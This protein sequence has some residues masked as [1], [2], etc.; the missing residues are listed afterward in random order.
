MRLLKL[1]EG[2]VRPLTPFTFQRLCQPQS[3]KQQAGPR[4]PRQLLS[5]THFLLPPQTPNASSFCL[6]GKLT[7]SAR[8]LGKPV[9][10]GPPRLPTTLRPGSLHPRIRQ[11]LWAHILDASEYLTRPSTGMS[12]EAG[13]QGAGWGGR[14]STCPRP[15]GGAQQQRHRARWRRMTDLEAS[16]GSATL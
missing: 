13:D 8:G 11:D 6:E 10:P 14:S 12:W 2:S 1:W 3:R 9:Q 5:T 16:P 15:H 7:L 4:F